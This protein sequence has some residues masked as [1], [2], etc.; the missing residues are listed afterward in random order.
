[1][2]KVRFC[3]CMSVAAGLFAFSEA[4]AV[5]QGEPTPES[6]EITVQLA[7]LSEPFEMEVLEAPPAEPE[8]SE[9]EI[10]VDYW[11]DGD[12]I[13][14][15]QDIAWSIDI[16]DPA[17][18]SLPLGIAPLSDQTVPTMSLGAVAVVSTFDGAVVLLGDEN[19]LI[20]I[21]TAGQVNSDIASLVGEFQRIDIGGETMLG[22]HSCTDN[23]ANC[24]CNGSGA[25]AT[26]GP[27]PSPSGTDR[28]ICRDSEG[29][30]V[31]T[32]DGTDCTCV[33]QAA[34]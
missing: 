15:L 2:M 33:S 31:C 5:P 12:A 30:M 26:C 16:D 4:L 27:A 13:A 7:S 11:G 29:T 25:G 8:L 32:E 1:M 18:S 21:R 10:T 28:V 3:A 17:H 9:G 34:Q 22:C 19:G 14:L 20:G 24:C 23:D 6:A